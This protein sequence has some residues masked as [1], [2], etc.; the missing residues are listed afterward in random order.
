MEPVHGGL[1]VAQLRGLI[2]A[3]ASG[4]LQPRRLAAAVTKGRG[5]PAGPHR[6]SMEAV[7]SPISAGDDEEQIGCGEA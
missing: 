4:Q 2:R 5:D 1:A 6:G 3:F 7:G